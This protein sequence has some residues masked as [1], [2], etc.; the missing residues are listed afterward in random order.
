MILTMSLSKI[1]LPG[2]R[3]GIVIARPDIIRAVV[4]MV[5]TSSLCPNNLGQALVTPYLEDGTLE[6]VCR[7]TLTPFYRGRAE[8]A[9]SLLPE[10]F[11]ES[12]PWRVHKSEGAM[13][14][15]L[16]FEGL[17]ITCQELYERC[18]SRGCF[19]NPGHH[20]SSPFRRRGNPGRTVMNASA[21]ASLR[22]RNSCARG[23]P[24]WRMKCARP[25]PVLN[26]NLTR[27]HEQHDRLRQSRRPD[28]PL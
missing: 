19:V 8:F 7:E 6:R 28:R 5:T 17:P 16:W 20:F 24:S 23:F 9:L 22:R 1:G 25:T 10:L 3:T 12:I 27:I 14:L 18:K 26:P 2:T 15:W 11:G 4:S 13:F 21:S